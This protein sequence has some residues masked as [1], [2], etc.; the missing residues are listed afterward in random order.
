MGIVLERSSLV[1][2][3]ESVM[4]GSTGYI[5]RKCV[6]ALEAFQ[7]IREKLLRSAEAA[8]QHMP[9]R[10]KAGG[11][12]AGSHSR[13]RLLAD[14]DYTHELIIP[15]KRARTTQNPSLG[16][17]PAVQVNS[18]GVDYFFSPK[19]DYIESFLCLACPNYAHD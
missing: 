18:R 19:R 13:R 1:I 8:L 5:C 14:E 17:S 2:D 6:R 7:T 9:S 15:A 16:F 3:E 4:S 10:P 11:S 12:V